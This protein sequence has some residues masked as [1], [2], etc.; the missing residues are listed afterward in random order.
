MRVLEKKAEE[1]QNTVDEEFKEDGEENKDES[2]EGKRIMGKFETFFY[3]EFTESLVITAVAKEQAEQRKMAELMFELGQKAYE[4]GMYGRAIEFPEA[5]LT[6]IPRPTLFG[7]EI[8]IWPAMAYE[9]NNH[10]KDCIALYKQ[11][12]KEHPSVRAYRARAHKLYIHAVCGDK[13]M[14]SNLSTNGMGTAVL[15]KSLYYSYIEFNNS[16]AATWTDK[17]KDKDQK[18]SVSTTNQLPSG[19]DYL[20]DF[21]V[22]K[23]PIGL[24]KNQTFW[25]ALILW[26]GLVGAALF[27]QR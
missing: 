1:V 17:Y 23:P 27:V 10:H 21:L 3:L 12:E 8:Q 2:E 13:F 14:A 24:E 9:A 26:I 16:Y 25:I 11:L 20:G 4:K 7:G 22:W 6:I 15:I 19:R 18:R 5:V